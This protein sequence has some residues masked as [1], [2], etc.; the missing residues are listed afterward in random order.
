MS[1]HRNAKLGLA[2]RHALVC[3]VENGTT[4][5]RAPPLNAAQATKAPTEQSVRAG[6]KLSLSTATRRVLLE[7]RR[8]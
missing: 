4:L 3:A 1:F 5:K 7:L 2:G 6:C 8:G